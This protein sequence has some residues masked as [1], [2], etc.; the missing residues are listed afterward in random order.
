MTDKVVMTEYGPVFQAEGKHMK[1]IVVY[2]N[3]IGG[4][5]FIGPLDTAL[6]ANLYAEEFEELNNV[7]WW[8]AELEPPY[9]A[10]DKSTNN[11]EQ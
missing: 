9:L 1:Y 2:G 11:N 7:E 6:E 4:L 8:I 5:K 3:P 10:A